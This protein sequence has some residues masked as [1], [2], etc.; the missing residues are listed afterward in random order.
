M[1][2]K[3]ILFA[4][5]GLLVVVTAV[6]AVLLQSG[7][8]F[9]GFSLIPSTIT[10]TYEVPEACGPHNI[11]GLIPADEPYVFGN[12]TDEMCKCDASSNWIINP[13]F[14]SMDVRLED[15][16]KPCVCNYGYKEEN[17]ACVPVSQEE[18][19]EQT[20]TLMT[21][22][23]DRADVSDSETAL[24]LNLDRPLSTVYTLPEAEPDEADEP[25]CIFTYPET[26][27]CTPNGEC[28]DNSHLEGKRCQCDEGYEYKDLKCEKIEE[29]SFGL[30]T[31]FELREPVEFTSVLSGESSDEEEVLAE[32]DVTSEVEDFLEEESA[33]EE[34]PEE[35]A[36]E[37]MQALPEPVCRSLNIVRPEYFQ[38]TEGQ[39]V[40][41]IPSAG[42]INQELAIVVDSDPGAVN[43]F[44]YKSME[45]TITFDNQGTVLDTKKTSVLMN[46]TDTSKGDIVTVW[47]MDEDLNG[48]QD[49]HDTLYVEIEEEEEEAVVAEQP[50]ELSELEVANVASVVPENTISE[51][52][53]V[54]Q[55]IYQPEP[56]YEPTYEIA[57]LHTAAVPEVPKNGPEVIFYV[58]GA[59]AIAYI[60][61][62]FKTC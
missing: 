23:Y 44:R 24:V 15:A 58:V 19:E 10:E 48:L 55:A 36:V 39:K 50:I 32:E 30:I 42:F 11:K 34:S 21:E 9:K 12:I 56:V 26:D 38:P 7:E 5:I 46:S 43:L 3:K 25:G 35:E 20:V 33:E 59:L 17:F 27:S 57:T 8:N 6:S 60:K 28:I 1:Q 61:K 52:V 45:G 22:D 41:R 37:T 40:I 53:T 31:N 54:P 2:K 16:E 29:S 47:A 13:S 62:G 4:I 49:C 18:T 51:A 14:A